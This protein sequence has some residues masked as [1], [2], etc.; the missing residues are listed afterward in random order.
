MAQ[1]SAGN[2]Y[3]TDVLRAG[4]HHRG[5]SRRHPG[6]AT[7]IVLAAVL[8]SLSLFVVGARAN[9]LASLG[10]DGPHPLETIQAAVSSLLSSTAPAGQNSSQLA[11]VAYP[12][13]V[14]QSVSPNGTTVNLFDYW[15]VDEDS[16]DVG[17]NPPDYR[18]V[19]I[20]A[21][22]DL[23]FLSSDYG[24]TPVNRWTRSAKPYF[25]ITRSTL[26]AD[27]YPQLAVESEQSLAYLFDGADEANG[28]QQGKAAHMDAGGLLQADR[29]GYY[30]YDATKN[31]AAYDAQ[32][33]AF[34][35]YDTWGV[36]RTS[37][38]ASNNNG[39]FF[40]FNTAQTIFRAQG[41]QLIQNNVYATSPVLNHWFGL[42]MTSRFVQQDGGTNRG[43]AVTYGFSGDDDVWI[44]IDGVLVGDLGGIHNATSVTIDFSTGAV[45]V[46]EDTNNSGAWDA[47]E[48]RY[49]DTTLRAQFKAADREG[50]PER[51]RDNTFADDTYHTLNFYY[52]ERGGGASNMKLRYNLV[53]IPESDVVK[54]DQESEPIAGAQFAL[55]ATGNTY[56]VAADQEPAYTGTTDTTG[57]MRILDDNGFPASLDELARMSAHWVLRETSAPT[58]YRGNTDVP[59]YFDPSITSDAMLL[60]ADPW[61][62]GAYAQPKLTVT[63][64]EHGVFDVSG[65]EITNG[66]GELPGG[67]MFAVVMQK[68][69]DG[70]WHPVVGD[71]LA[72][73]TVFDA[74]GR[75]GAVSA[76]QMGDVDLF[77]LNAN[78]LYEAEVAD[79]PGDIKTYAWILQNNPDLGSVNDAR[80]A[81]GYFYTTADR[82]DDATVGNTVQVRS[83][84]EQDMERQFATRLYVTNIENR[85][86][87]QKVDEEGN[88][89]TG[90]QFSLYRAQDIVQDG[91][92]WSV[93]P[94][95]QPV[96]QGTTGDLTLVSGDGGTYTLSGAAAYAK[97]L[98]TPLDEGEYCLVETA[99]PDGYA[100]NGTCVKV[101]ID[102]TGV[103]A[104]AGTASDGVA[105]ARGVGRVVGSMQQFTVD[106]DVDATLHDIKAAL[107]TAPS[108]EGAATAWS[109]PNWDGPSTGY[110]ADVMYL[111]YNDPGDNLPGAVFDYAPARADGA[112]SLMVDEGW[113]KLVI[114]QDYDAPGGASMATKTNLGTTDLAG[115]FSGTVVVRVTDER[116]SGLEVSKEVMGDNAPDVPFSFRL[117]LHAADGTELA[118]EYAAIVTRGLQPQGEAFKVKSGSAF[119]L[120]GGETLHVH[121]MPDGARFEVEEVGVAS[122]AD[123]AALPA[124][125][126]LD[127]IT[128]NGA[129]ASE[130]EVARGVASGTIGSTA[131][132]EP[133]AAVVFTN[134]YRT[135]DVTLA[136]DTLLR[137]QKTLVGRAWAAGETYSFTL[138]SVSAPEGVTAPGAPDVSVGR[139]SD[140]AAGVS[141]AT[142]A[143][144]TFTAAGDYAYQVREVL[145]AENVGM[146]YDTHVAT[147]T[148]RVRDDGAG[149]LVVAGPLADD[150]GIIYDNTEATTEA[151]RAVRDAA[152]FT[153]VYATG[154]VDFGADSGLIATKV[155][156]GSAVPEG[157]FAAVIEALDGDGTT[158]ADASAKLGLDA[159]AGYAAGFPAADEG[160]TSSVGLVPQADSSLMFSQE[161][162]GKTYRYC[163]WERQPTT[164]GTFSGEALDGAELTGAGDDQRWVYQGVSYDRTVYTV[165]IAVEDGG[166]GLLRVTTTVEGDDGSS[167]QYVCTSDR[168]QPAEQAVV[169]FSNTKVDAAGPDEPSEPS[170]PTE[171]DEPT[172]PDE[173]TEPDEPTTPDNP[174]DPDTPA[175]SDKPTEP[176]GPSGSEEPSEPSVPADPAEPDKPM[177]P[178]NL[179][180][181]GDTALAPILLTAVVALFLIAAGVRFRQK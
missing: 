179:A 5:A 92:S 99:A 2:A 69:A 86:V 40:P 156:E 125:F 120:K 136:A 58:G 23:R 127:G 172:G 57:V 147:V 35:V 158:A 93:V 134:R 152:A 165:S 109:A 157:R 17:A 21:G 52:L 106:D 83:L 28:G 43:H 80:Y 178:D 75:D 107:V 124:G 68:A 1:V 84:T 62:T 19:G 13:H 102:A 119:E 91:A 77:A 38:I 32:A 27:G 26:G 164:D 37:A 128:V 131:A 3:G 54:V 33:N 85:L 46:F 50:S 95:A 114:N 140:D 161:D 4:V 20:N 53:S 65:R 73:W 9:P 8:G 173:P 96:A 137:V 18:N 146:T 82:L 175:D 167:K 47:G 39:Q 159:D 45:T 115:L 126:A 56:A 31:F 171:P 148:V 78:G 100:L 160:K 130:D 11:G 132:G 42:S 154:V 170:G 12:D 141:T 110:R 14:V 36:K 70:T 118:G 49:V 149:H 98:R 153:N 60:S 151:D 169:P 59:L 63:T 123:G 150:P 71:A 117:T 176:E 29:D 144:L 166:G 177:T 34:H 90:S 94:D 142:F 7:V 41:D 143:P 87:V 155:L 162:I 116:V 22:H 66:E 64:T 133:G 181:T 25:G 112:S 129:A 72:G 30:Y 24:E 111:Q 135:E 97:G 145:G 113:S 74:Q 79:M 55:F 101:V 104:D 51:W 16:T 44:Y 138:T 180:S 6:V 67:L 81:V 174:T 61:T 122:D 108:Y 10:G 15:L 88:P 105:V 76:A 168:S 121:G 103:Y 163:V 89:V 139:P 48:P